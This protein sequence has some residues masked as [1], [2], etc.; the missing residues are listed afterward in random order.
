MPS[1]VAPGLRFHQWVGGIYG[2]R[3]GHVEEIVCC[4]NGIIFIPKYYKG[5]DVVICL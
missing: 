2:F 3:Q 5:N 4:L 1:P